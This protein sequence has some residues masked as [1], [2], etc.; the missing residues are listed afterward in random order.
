MPLSNGLNHVALLTADL[1]RFLSFYCEVFDATVLLDVTEGGMRHAGVDLGGGSALH[2]FCIDGNAHAS[3][4]PDIFGRGHLD[5]LAINVPDEQALNQAQHRL[6]A[7]GASDGRINDFGILKSVAF[8]DPDG[9]EG[10]VALWASTAAVAISADSQPASARGVTVRALLRQAATSSD[11][12]AMRKAIDLLFSDTL[13][14]LSPDDEYQLRHQDYVMEMP[15]SGERVRGRDAMLAMQSHYPSPPAITVRRVTGARGVYFIE[16][17]N[18]YGGAV[19]HVAA[20][21]ELDTDGLIIR[22]TRYYAEPF[23]APSWR[24]EWAERI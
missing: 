18:D 13:D 11:A 10:E 3:G 15:Q 8:R 2:A 22:D 21:W 23:H 24:S 20:I 14:A 19:S 5:H 6:L 16:G 12:T 1:D 17:E 4:S 9:F 7:R